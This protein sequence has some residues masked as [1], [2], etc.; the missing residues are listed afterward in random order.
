MRDQP[1]ESQHLLLL[2]ILAIVT[3]TGM[4]C[5][6][7]ASCWFDLSPGHDWL[8]LPVT[9][10]LLPLL[11]QLYQGVEGP[12]RAECRTLLPGLDLAAHGLQHL[13]LQAHGGDLPVVTAPRG[14]NLRV[15]ISQALSQQGTASAQLSPRLHPQQHLQ[16]HAS[17]PGTPATL[18]CGLA[19]A[20][21]T[22]QAP[23][24]TAAPSFASLHEEHQHHVQQQQQRQ[25]EGISAAAAGD[26][27][28]GSSANWKWLL[29]GRFSG[30]ASD[31]GSSLSSRP[32]SP[33]N[34]SL[35]LPPAPQGAASG[36]STGQATVEQPV[37]SQEQT[38]AVPGAAA[39][40]A[41]Q[42]QRPRA[43]TLDQL[44]L[45]Q[46]Q[47]APL[48]LGGA[49]HWTYDG[50]PATQGPPRSI[51]PSPLDIAY[52]ARAAGA[53]PMARCCCTAVAQTAY[54]MNMRCSQTERQ[55]STICVCPCCSTHV[56]HAGA[57]CT[58]HAAAVHPAISPATWQPG[59]CWKVGRACYCAATVR[60][61]V[62]YMLLYVA[63][64]GVTDALAC[65]LPFAPALL[66][67]AAVALSMLVSARPSAQ[68]QRLRHRASAA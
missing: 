5:C 40:G 26:A 55:L 45:I 29:R 9:S 43:P 19:S 13:D 36:A 53:G 50:T 30:R 24:L 46:T 25:Q 57:I 2:L 41:A 51:R 48:R 44:E 42:V 38:S 59:R 1:G 54:G 28:A 20:E 49:R 21:A 22:P 37:G 67:S 61:H 23:A 16:Q 66:P 65:R 31:G 10:P 12:C 62:L 7:H 18:P 64:P 35:S 4:C 11:P 33:Q 15:A 60:I 63:L 27:A 32:H 39:G 3:D 52:R 14:T 68:K 58:S 17:V 34:Q 6:L 8:P 47:V 56:A